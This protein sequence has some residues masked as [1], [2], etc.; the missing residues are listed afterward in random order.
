MLAQDIM[1]QGIIYE[2]Y[3]KNVITINLY[4]HSSQK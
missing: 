3:H 2:S 1:S 4:M